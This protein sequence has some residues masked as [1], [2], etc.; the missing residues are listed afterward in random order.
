MEPKDQTPSPTISL[1][2]ETED[3]ND[4]TNVSTPNA[5]HH[6][7][8]KAPSTSDVADDQETLRAVKLQAADLV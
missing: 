2:R 5:R 6:P 3:W 4:A 1:A 7:R 8:E